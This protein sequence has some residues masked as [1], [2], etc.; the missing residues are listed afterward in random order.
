MTLTRRL[1][2]PPAPRGKAA[3]SCKTSLAL[4]TSGK[5]VVCNGRESQMGIDV[6]SRDRAAIAA[7]PLGEGPDRWASTQ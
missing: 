2:G 6:L 5:D 3:R 7:L 4:Q 1:E